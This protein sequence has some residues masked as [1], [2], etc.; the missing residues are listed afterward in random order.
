MKLRLSPWKRPRP[1]ATKNF[2]PPPSLPEAAP[3]GAPPLPQS[4]ENFSVGALSVSPLPHLRTALLG[5]CISEQLALAA[6]QDI[7]QVSH[8]L[9]DSSPF[10]TPP[11]FAS[12]D[13][14]AVVIHLTLRTLLGAAQPSGDGDLF[15]LKGGDPEAHKKQTLDTLAQTIDRL[16]AHLPADLPVF[17]LSLVEPSD[18]AQGLIALPSILSLKTIVQA[19]NQKLAEIMA[20]RSHT[21]YVELND[22]IRFYGDATISDLYISHASHA[23]FTGSPDSRRLCC[24]IWD[25]IGALYRVFKQLDPIKLIITD[26]DNTLWK[27]VAAE[28]DEIIPWQFTEGWPLGYA[29]AL[30]ACKARGILLAIASKNDEATVRDLCAQI[31]RHRLSFS[32][33]CSIRV[34]WRSK[35]QNIAE[36]LVE[37]NLLPES[38]LFIDDNP[39]E[40]AEVKA[41]FPTMRT[42]T[43]PQERWKHILC[44]APET[45]RKQLSTESIQRTEL[46][47]AKIERDKEAASM[48]RPTFLRSL[49]LALEVVKL[50]STDHDRFARAFELLNKT[51]QFNTT[52]QR[53]SES[54]L[55]G[56]FAHGGMIYS[57]S[58]RDKLA[59]HGLIGLALVQGD[60]LV[61]MVLSCRVFGLGI[62]TAMLNEV[63]SQAST[64]L[65][66]QWVETG[67]NHSCQFLY[68]DHGWT[69]IPDA[70]NWYQMG[71]T[72]P[73]WPDWIAH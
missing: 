70:P 22:L 18:T 28:A 54:E 36:I 62:E 13:Y 66:A 64:T 57:F 16:M 50:T 14:D 35:A 39:L 56:F 24:Q 69:L 23:G 47:Q 40:I 65:R 48:D 71:T 21:F 72:P 25:R 38:V 60:Q 73:V 32:D 33:F 63:Q 55:A 9:M 43:V 11:T 27:G 68:T 61:Q 34:N 10:D 20:L 49:Q 29:E 4:P 44:Y 2:S 1:A 8:W 41:S 3:P 19:M 15:Y 6:D 42:L 37:T 58:A 59:N 45:Q 31:W 12:G 51:N 7:W 46:I 67:R 26:L 53:W 52:G 30:L 17:F 5:T